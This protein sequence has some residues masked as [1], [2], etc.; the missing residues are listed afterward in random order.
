M[1]YKRK[2]R[3][4]PCIDRAIAET[5]RALTTGLGKEK[6][7]YLRALPTSSGTNFGGR[8]VVSPR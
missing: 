2:G 6:Y 4:E 3:G 7:H 8:P 5:E 1:G